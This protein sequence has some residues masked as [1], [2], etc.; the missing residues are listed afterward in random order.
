L[1]LRRKTDVHFVR[2]D[3]QADQFRLFKKIYT[4]YDTVF[5][6]E[7]LQGPRELSEVSII[8]FDPTNKVIIENDRISLI[9]E[10]ERTHLDTTDDPISPIRGIL[11]YV[12]DQRFRYVGGAV[13]YISYDAISAWIDLRSRSRKRRFLSD[14]FPILEF[15]VYTDG[16]IVDHATSTVYYFHQGNDSRSS[17]IAKLLKKPDEDF[18][19]PFDFSSLTNNVSRYKY[20]NMVKKAKEFIY[21][22]DIFQ[23]VLSRSL[24]F[25]I[26]G[27]P[28]YVYQNL[29]RINPSPYMYF[30]K[31]SSGVQIIGSS[32]EML[33]RVSQ[34]YIETYPIAGTRPV[35]TDPETN[36]K[37]MKELVNDKKEIAEHT[38]L[39]DLA[40]NDVGRVSKY[41]SVSVRDLM[42]VRRFSHVQHMVTHVSGSLGDSYDQFDAI[43][44]LFPAGTVSGAPKIR[45]MEIIDE[46]EPY[47]RGPYAGAL[48]YFSSND[49]CD[50]AIILRSL[51]I[52]GKEA[53][54]QAGAGI[55]MES[56]PVAEWNE[57]EQKLNA[58]LMAL[59]SSKSLQKEP[60]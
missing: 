33:L 28:L 12:E 60:K 36:E 4:I 3:V 23:A 44:A 30:L 11:P 46:L 38:M 18:G 34:R 52:R 17:Q 40:R 54:S 35:V 9:D 39:V 22:G 26:S 24:R 41:G 15:G 6:L 42:A 59:Q 21:K 58:I 49:S 27:D 51:F 8:G 13:G 10:N 16:I 1:N 45:A 55:V 56:K 43:K 20:M 25:Q 53:Y 47:R 37:L 7:S 57:T 29:R 48:G 32:P 19:Q 31:T 2:L 14:T 5:L 50:F